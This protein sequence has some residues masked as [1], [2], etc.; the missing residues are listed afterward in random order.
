MGGSV[1][2]NTPALAISNVT[3]TLPL[4]LLTHWTEVPA[5]SR[6]LLGQRS[7]RPP[8]T[9]SFMA[10]RLTVA[11]SSARTPALKVKLQASRAWMGGP[12][13]LPEAGGQ[14]RSR[15]ALV[16]WRAL[17]GVP[18]SAHRRSDG[19]WRRCASKRLRGAGEATVGVQR[20]PV[21]LVAILEPGVD[22]LFVRSPAMQI[23][24]FVE[25]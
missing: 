9:L 23:G 2:F 5:V 19:P 6:G 8:L 20:L 17:P 12:R 11:L 25:Q 14:E 24:V 3:V 16:N 13:P 1:C 21:D 22:G 7:H 10:L 18:I 4:P 15:N